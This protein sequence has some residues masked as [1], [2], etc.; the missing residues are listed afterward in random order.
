MRYTI[1][2]NECYLGVVFGVFVGECVVVFV[3]EEA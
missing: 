1:V 3:H 2:L